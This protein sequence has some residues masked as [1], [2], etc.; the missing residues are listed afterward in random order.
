M[1]P[2]LQQHSYLQLVTLKQTRE[3]L[4][5]GAHTRL[6]VEQF[7]TTEAIDLIAP[8]VARADRLGHCA[9]IPQPMA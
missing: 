7:V 5:D 8:R 4:V 9:R 1:Q 6:V 2:R 3:E